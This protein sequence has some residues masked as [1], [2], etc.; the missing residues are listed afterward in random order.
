[1]N[2]IETRRNFLRTAARGV[3]GA[4]AVQ[5]LPALGVTTPRD[6]SPVRSGAEP[7]PAAAWIAKQ[8]SRVSER[9]WKLLQR[10]QATLESNILRGPDPATKDVFGAQKDLSKPEPWAPLRGISPSPFGYR[11]I[12]NWDSAFHAVAVARWDPELAREQ[13]RIILDRQL[14]G[15]GFPDVVFED[16][17][18]V[19]DF[20]KPP[21]MG[22]A[23]ARVDS[24]APAPAFLSWAYDRFVRNEEHW[25]AR[26]G[27]EKDGLFHYDSEKPV[28]DARDHDAKL[29]SGWD[30]SVRWDNGCR[31]LW[32]VDLNCFMVML[33][34]SLASMAE[35]LR[36][37]ADVKKW[38]ARRASLAREINARLW[39]R[40]TERY[41]DYDFKRGQFSP[42]LSPA[43]FMPLYVHVASEH[44][45]ANMARLAADPEK[46]S[47]G[48]PSVAYN[49]PEYRSDQYWRG[50]TWLN[51]AYFALHGL[52]DYGHTSVSGACRNSILNWCTAEESAL[53]EYYDSRTGRGLGAR[54]FGW[55][56]AFV[57]EFILNWGRS[58][59]QG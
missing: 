3:L 32:P 31:T 45:A 7:S 46:F 28:M 6:A 52:R 53:Y 37:G 59:A 18:V 35:R 25:V 17:N 54:Q 44:Q 47:P 4:A 24:Y 9:D 26:R 8:K 14:P 2:L 30:T 12:W 42:V 57:I 29:E 15:G 55:T 20:G 51:I 5:A 34:D 21:V 22:W 1:M 41:L 39:D 40:S 11:G 58:A 13:I 10:A 49:D 19:T 23:C 33:Y 16:G 36:R 50:P 27:G 38:R 48:F 43:C 56:A